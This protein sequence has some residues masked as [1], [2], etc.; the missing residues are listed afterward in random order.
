M[1]D[2]LIFAEAYR[3]L[4]RPVL[5]TGNAFDFRAS[6]FDP[7]INTAIEALAISKTGRF[8]ELVVDGHDI[9]SS[10]MELPKQWSSIELT[11][12]L[13]TSGMVPI[14]KNFDQLMARSKSFVRAQLPEV[15]Y[16]LEED[17][18][19]S[20]EPFDKRIITLQSLCRLIFL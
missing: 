13:D 5:A 16:L 11:F 12:V 1:V 6:C 10:V 19:S 15:F 4:G 7:K 9:S 20:E 18:L 14:F 2:V 17:I 3:S 8:D